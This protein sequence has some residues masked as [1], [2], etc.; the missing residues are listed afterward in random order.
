[1]LASPVRRDAFHLIL[2]REFA[3]LQGD[4]F[5]LFCG[6][7]VVLFGELVEAIVKG[8]VEIG[9]L[10]ILVVACQQECLTSCASA[11]FMAA[12]L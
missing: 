11:P 5:D 10:S 6:G 8:V 3:L 7:E 4:F 9:K 1:M 12:P 2:E